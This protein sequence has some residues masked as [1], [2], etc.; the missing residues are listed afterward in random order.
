MPRP[1]I[2]PVIDWKPVHESGKAFAD[3]LQTAENDDERAKAQQMQQE[4]DS[5]AP[6]NEVASQLANLEHP[7][8]VIAIAE[9]WCG[10]VVR[11]IPVLQA[12][13]RQSDNLKVR[14]IARGDHP[15]VF[16]RYLTN[17]GEAIPKIIFFNEHW[18]EVGNW[19]PM[20]AQERELIARGKA[21]GC[22]GD[23]RKQVSALY[24]ADTGKKRVFQELAHLVGIAATRSL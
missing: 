16:A 11:H 8:Y 12:M 6:P 7:V 5:L 13:A 21:A 19:G 15:D 24:E 20:P 1:P 10:D 23:A 18:V 17:G 14:Y 2:L 22:V 3:W 4:A 9:C